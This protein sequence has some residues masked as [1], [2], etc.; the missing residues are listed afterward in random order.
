MN[1]SGT[2]EEV[3]I[4]VLGVGQV[5]F[6]LKVYCGGWEREARQDVGVGVGV[7]RSDASA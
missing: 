1:S 3:N 5:I 4:E 7:L 6:G 2:Y